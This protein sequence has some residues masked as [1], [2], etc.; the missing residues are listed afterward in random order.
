[1]YLLY[2]ARRRWAYVVLYKSIQLRYPRAVASEVVK[3]VPC[4]A[5][6]LLILY[7]RSMMVRLA[8]QRQ[9]ES[10]SVL[11]KEK[12]QGRQTGGEC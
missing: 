11:Q 8:E 1:V 2:F 12:G 10:V 3:D 4:L 7:R 9:L 6:R 5:R